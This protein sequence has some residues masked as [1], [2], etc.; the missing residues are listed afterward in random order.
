MRKSRAQAAKDEILKGSESP[1]GT[2]VD[3]TPGVWV[4]N[5]DTKSKLLPDAKGNI[6]PVSTTDR[7]K[8]YATKFRLGL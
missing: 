3:S 4:S 1:N 5:S 2:K 8:E 6:E 7:G